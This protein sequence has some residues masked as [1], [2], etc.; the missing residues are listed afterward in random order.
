MDASLPIYRLRTMQQRIDARQQAGN[1]IV[2][3]FFGICGGLALF[4]SIVGLTGTLSY[5][6][7]RRV[8]EFGIRAAVGASPAD[9]TRLVLG[10]TL[11]MAGPG[12]AIGLF[13]ALLLSWLFA[14]RA[15]GLNLDSPITFALVG[16]LQLTIAIVAAAIPGRRAA[17]VAPLTALRE[18]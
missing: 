12:I 16:F 3:K 13:G 5:A 14:A 8:R 6:V 17:R 18:S 7:A 4:L 15:S 2:V 11:R 9:Q 10:F 1:L